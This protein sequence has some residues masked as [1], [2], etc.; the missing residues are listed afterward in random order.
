MEHGNKM[1]SMQICNK[2]PDHIQA[3]GRTRQQDGQDADF[4]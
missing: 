3:E 1:V 4:Q 2:G